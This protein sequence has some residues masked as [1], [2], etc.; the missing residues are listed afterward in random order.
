V[1]GSGREK[2]KSPVY[3]LPGTRKDVERL[4]DLCVNFKGGGKKEKR[5][6][7][8]RSRNSVPK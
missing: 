3:I 7:I 6:G 1:L 4:V 2:G 5:G 8:G